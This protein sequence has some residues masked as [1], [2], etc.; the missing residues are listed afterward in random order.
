[1][2]ENTLA[3][4]S[5]IK[6]EVMEEALW[7][8]YMASVLYGMCHTFLFPRKV[9]ANQLTTTTI[10]S[11]VFFLDPSLNYRIIIHDPKF[12]HI[13]TKFGIFPRIWLEYKTGQNMEAG[14]YEFSE[15]TVI[16][17][18]L[19]NRPEQPCEEEED[20]DFLQCVKTSQARMV[21]CRPPWDIW[22]PHTIP[23]CQTMEQLQE[24]EKIDTKLF[25][26]K[27]KV[28]FL[29][30]TG[31][32]IPC[33]YKV[34]VAAAIDSNLNSDFPAIQKVWRSK[35][36]NLYCLWKQIRK[37][38]R[39]HHKLRRHRRPTRKGDL[40]LPGNLLHSRDRWIAESVYWRLLPV[41]LGLLGVSV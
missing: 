3:L 12:Y 19:L 17:H 16:E 24:Y 4:N 26:I 5:T 10:Q 18:H 36:W 14:N 20:Y 7:S 31:C 1:M 13:L 34:S 30:K 39:G 11:S 38:I 9:E 2:R 22:S 23:L 29:S 35:E 41:S 25:S 32:K 27:R 15:I 8:S 37:Q 33:S 21:G 28:K 40:G 6:Q